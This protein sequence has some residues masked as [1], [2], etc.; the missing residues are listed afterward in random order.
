MR[1]VKPIAVAVEIPD[2]CKG[3]APV[4]YT[5]LAWQVAGIQMTVE[6]E[7]RLKITSMPEQHVSAV[8][9]VTRLISARVHNCIYGCIERVPEWNDDI[10]TGM[11]IPLVS[12]HLRQ[13]PQERLAELSVAGNSP[14]ALPIAVF[15]I[16]LQRSLV[17]DVH[18]LLQ[19]RACCKGYGVWIAL[20]LVPKEG[21]HIHGSEAFGVEHGLAGEMEVGIQD[22]VGEALS[23]HMPHHE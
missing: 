4:Q 7:E 21:E 19:A 15:Q 13:V 10:Q 23:F 17:R 16:C 9:A 2:A 20:E 5:V 1:V 3:V 12:A 18:M 6:T 8:I 14:R 22:F 11:D